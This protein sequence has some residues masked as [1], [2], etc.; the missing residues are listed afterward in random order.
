M[1]RI[2]ECNFRFTVVNHLSEKGGIL[3]C[4][5]LIILI[6]FFYIM[7]LWLDINKTIEQNAAIYFEKAKKARKKAQGAREALAMHKK[8]LE[9][10]EI[11]AV[12]LDREER[13][14]IAEKA[15]EKQ[16]RE[17][18]EKFRWF[19][20]SE[21][22]LV[23]GGRDAT[24]NDIIVK[25]HVEPNDIIFHAEIAGSPFCIVKTL[26][27]DVGEM[28]LKETAQFC[29]ANSRAWKL[30]LSNLEVYYVKPE[31]V[32]KEA[33]AGEYLGKGA[34]MIYGKKNK[35]FADVKICIGITEHGKIMAAPEN[36]CKKNCMYFITIRPGRIKKSDAA[37]RIKKL[38]EDKTGQKVSLDG[39][40]SV[41][42]PGDC[43]LI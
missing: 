29:A 34:F 32:T 8:R 28:T 10:I 16:R 20:S 38:I 30:G 31:Q 42:P 25:K 27:K 15:A 24:T 37:K 9:E 22:F 11:K 13:E 35:M 41:M 14:K 4:K 2:P 43:E 33:P 26:G 3:T 1:L 7:R 18:Y 40:M 36:A 23:I 12:K 39:I 6:S 21:G 5:H 17:W 19:I